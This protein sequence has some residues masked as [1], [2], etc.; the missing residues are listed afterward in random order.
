[1]TD[2]RNIGGV[3]DWRDLADA[4]RPEDPAEIAA[5]IRRQFAGGLKPRDIATLLRVPLADVLDALGE[6]GGPRKPASS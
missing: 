4:H 5:E 3:L 2:P 6:Q 1:M